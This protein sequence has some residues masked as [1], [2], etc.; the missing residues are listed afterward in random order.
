MPVTS[1]A[2]TDK[3]VKA[4]ALAGDDLSSGQP[5]SIRTIVD[6][7][8]TPPHDS[9]LSAMP[10]LEEY[11]VATSSPLMLTADPRCT[12]QVTLNVSDDWQLVIPQ[13]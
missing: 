4:D 6:D 10:C 3:S 11:H 7:V 9:Q 5:F 12:T 8:Q 2:F 1:L 13:R